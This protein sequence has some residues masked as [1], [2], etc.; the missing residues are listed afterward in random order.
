MMTIK[1]KLVY[2]P[3]VV[4]FLHPGHINIINVA[5][6]LGEVI[7]GLFSDEAVTSYKRTPYMNYEQRKIV[8]ENVKGVDQVVIQDTR[9][10]ED[11]LRKYKPD[12]MVHGTDWREGPLKEVRAKAIAALAEWG[13]K[14]VEPEYTQGIS[15]TAMHKHLGIAGTER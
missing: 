4:D 9:D 11:N 2:V 15:S 14:I 1:K 3:M 10:Y 5:A 7:V 13:G 6:E 12:Y 8:I